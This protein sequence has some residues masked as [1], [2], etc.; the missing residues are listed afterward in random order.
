MNKLFITSYTNFNC[1]AHLPSGKPTKS[2]LLL[3]DNS[4]EISICNKELYNPAFM[5]KHPKSETY[6]VC[7]ESI[8]RGHIATISENEIKQVITSGGKSSCFLAFDPCL[9]YLVNIN[10][11]DSSISIHSIDNKD[12]LLSE[13]I[14]IFKDKACHKANGLEE[15]LVNRQ[16]EPHYHSV[17]FVEISKQTYLFVPDLGMDKIHIFEF[18][19]DKP[20]ICLITSVDLPSGSGPR[21]IV[22]NDDIIYVVNELNSTV[23]VFELIKNRIPELLVKNTKCTLPPDFPST[24]SKCGGIMLHQTE[25]YLLVSNRGHNSITI[26]KCCNFDIEIVQIFST[27]GE[28]PRHFTFDKNCSNIY[29]ANQDTDT[30]TIF[31]FKKGMVQF[32][33][34]INVCSP[35]FILTS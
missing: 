1:L 13:P 29:V 3:L 32:I 4:D 26:F 21:Y 22:Q 12:Y 2:P 10:Y 31:Y 17:L 15:H 20:E 23:T 34:S 30:V 16:S 9:K 35:N 11:W 18:I 24:K 6:Y 14:Y 27:L 5:I 7:L 28:T 8:Y 33:K 19:Y 25:P